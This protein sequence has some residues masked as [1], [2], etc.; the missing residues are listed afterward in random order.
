MVAEEALVLA[1]YA[2]ITAADAYGLP[3]PLYSSTVDQGA[4]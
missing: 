2:A 1:G 4:F 3:F